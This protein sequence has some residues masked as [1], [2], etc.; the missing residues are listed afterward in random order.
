[1]H[2]QSNSSLTQRPGHTGHLLTKYSMFHTNHT[3]FLSSVA[4]RKFSKLEVR[5]SNL[6]GSRLFNLF[7]VGQEDEPFDF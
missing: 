1:M 4:E 7:R 6:L 3:G 2:Y 5:S